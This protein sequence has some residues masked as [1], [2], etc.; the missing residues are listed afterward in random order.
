[1]CAGDDPTCADFEIH[2][3]KLIDDLSTERRGFLKNG[4]P[5]EITRSWYRGDAYDFVAELSAGS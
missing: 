4:Q 1:M 2:K 3:R 5:V